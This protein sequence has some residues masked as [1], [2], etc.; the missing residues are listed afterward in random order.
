MN[1]EITG[2]HV[3]VTPALKSYIMRRL[4]KFDRM[5]EDDASIHVVIGVEKQRHTA[6]I[7]LKSRLLKLT[8]KGQTHDMYSSILL[9]IDKIERQALK[10]KSRIIEVKRSKA[11]EKAVEKKMGVRRGAAPPSGGP[12]AITMEEAE[13]KPMTLE[14]AELELAH[15]E[16]PFVVF[17]DAESGEVNVLYRSRK[18][19][20]SL[21]RA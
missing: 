10:Q 15:S 21:I 7:L 19:A 18:G 12:A 2:R 5:L 4:R 17:R 9:A 6:E 8:G 1:V 14:E 13:Q 3:D 20:L 16:N 11:R